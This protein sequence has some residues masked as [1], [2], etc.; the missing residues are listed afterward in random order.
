[1]LLLDDPPYHLSEENTISEEYISKKKEDGLSKSWI[2]VTE[3]VIYLGSGLSTT[4]EMWRSLEEVFTEDTK[5]RERSL[6]V[7]FH[8]GYN[9]FSI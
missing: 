4:K 9:D 3:E 2:E 5:D 8:N 1:M 6:V 7:D